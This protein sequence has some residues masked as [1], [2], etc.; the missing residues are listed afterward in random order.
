MFI[1]SL[2]IP[3]SPSVS[4]ITF[5]FFSSLVS[6]A[7]P[8]PLFLSLHLHFLLPHSSPPILSFTLF[9]LLRRMLLLSNFL[10]IPGP[11]PGVMFRFF[12]LFS[13]MHRTNSDNLP[14]NNI[15]ELNARGLM[16]SRCHQTQT[17][18]AVPLQRRRRR[19]YCSHPL[20]WSHCCLHSMNHLHCDNIPHDHYLST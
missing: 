14:M 8:T 9:S 11:P 4:S 1:P 17:W 10:L 18:V 20:Y 3:L 12:S 5:S 7:P 16:T 2:V 19:S 6:L 15:I 13:V